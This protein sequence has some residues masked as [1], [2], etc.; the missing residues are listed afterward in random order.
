MRRVIVPVFVAGLALTA[1]MGVQPANA[2]PRG[3]E[4]NLAGAAKISPGLTTVKRANKV[5]LTGVKLTGCRIGNLGAPGF[6]TTISA[7]VTTSPNPIS[8]VAN[9]ASGNLA[10]KATVRWSTGKTTV[11]SLTTRG[12]TANQLIQGKVTSSTERNLKPGDL[13]AGEAVFRPTT[14]AQNCRN[15]VTNVTF[16]GVFAMGSPR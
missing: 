8:T 13:V 6:P 4:C 15:P 9:C 5:T 2:A 7:T 16:S 12:I 11:A 10:L 14:V 3:A 1:V